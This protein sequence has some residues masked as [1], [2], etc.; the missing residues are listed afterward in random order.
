[1]ISKEL[2]AQICGI[3]YYYLK[4]L[5]SKFFGTK[6]FPHE[7]KVFSD[8]KKVQSIQY[9]ELKKIVNFKPKYL[10]PNALNF[11]LEVNKIYETSTEVL[12]LRDARVISNEGFII[13]SSHRI[14][15]DNYYANPQITK[16]KKTKI[17]LISLKHHVQG[18]MRLFFLPNKRID[19]NQAFLITTRWSNN[20]FHWITDTI[21]KLKVLEDHYPNV[22]NVIINKTVHS[23][24][25]ESLKIYKEN[26]DFYESSDESIICVKNL[27]IPNTSGASYQKIEYLRQKFKFEN[28]ISKRIFVSRKNAKKRKIINENQVYDYLKMYGF[29][30]VILEEIAFD[31]QVKIFSQAEIVVAPH[32]AGLTNIIFSEYSKTKI[33]EFIPNYKPERF[34]MYFEISAYL[35]L[36]YYCIVDNKKKPLHKRNNIF[37]DITEL[38]KIINMLKI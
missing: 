8:Y 10:T 4:K 24:Q 36:D 14:L 13:D 12:E 26:F 18:I 11:K 31:D 9:G 28:Q 33:I 25:I 5:L 1:M 29:E 34:L 16:N 27:I 17:G 19:L 2:K 38:K 30:K 32:G 15:L 23:F 21:S 6:F 22:K 7:V 37:V 35:N 20:Y 3:H